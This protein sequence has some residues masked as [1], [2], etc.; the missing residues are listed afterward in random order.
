LALQRLIFGALAKHGRLFGLR[1]EY[2]YP[3]VG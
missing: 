1:A 2:P 3:G